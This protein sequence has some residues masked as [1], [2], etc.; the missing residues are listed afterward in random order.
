MKITQLPSLLH[1]ITGGCAPPAPV[2]GYP[3]ALLPS[4]SMAPT[5]P[6]NGGADHAMPAL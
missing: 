4:G 1:F 2:P 6:E 5:I 3:L